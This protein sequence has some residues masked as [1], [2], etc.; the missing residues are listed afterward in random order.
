MKNK[1]YVCD[2]KKWRI[3]DLIQN[4]EQNKKLYSDSEDLGA[5]DDPKFKHAFR[6]NWRL[7]DMENQV[8]DAENYLKEFIASNINLKSLYEFY[9]SE[10]FDE[11]KLLTIIT[12]S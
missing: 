9:N 7:S 6:Y 5:D 1:E 4:M 10:Y 3:K 8:M 11:G 2:S 12:I